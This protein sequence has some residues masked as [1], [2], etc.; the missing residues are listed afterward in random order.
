[1]RV[2][3][4]QKQVVLIAGEGKPS[5]FRDAY[6]AHPAHAPRWARPAR[7]LAR[8]VTSAEAA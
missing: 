8:V 3:E 2:N 4:M 6:Q 7:A 1:M 5:G